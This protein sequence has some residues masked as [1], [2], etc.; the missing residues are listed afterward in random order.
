MRRSRSLERRPSVQA[1]V[2]HRSMPKLQW[3]NMEGCGGGAPSLSQVSEEQIDRVTASQAPWQGR[4]LA[5]QKR[6]YPLCFKN[7]DN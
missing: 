6:G 4:K 5:V 7:K 1:G 3:W 2:P